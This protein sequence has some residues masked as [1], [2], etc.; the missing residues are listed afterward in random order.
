M[1]R[2]FATLDE[3]REAIEHHGV[4][5]GVAVL[6]SAVRDAANGEQFAAEVQRRYGLEPHVLTGDE[7]ATLTFLGATSERDPGRHARRR[8]CSTSAA[9]RPRS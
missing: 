4:D 9:A 7:E 8:W 5:A 2:V 1:E 3:Y 6:T